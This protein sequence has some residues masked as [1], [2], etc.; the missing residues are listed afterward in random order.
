MELIDADA[1]NYGEQTALISVSDGRPVLLRTYY[2]PVAQEIRSDAPEPGADGWDWIEGVNYFTDGKSQ[3]SSEER[4]FDEVTPIDPDGLE[5]SLTTAVSETSYS[6]AWLDD[7]SA[8]EVRRDGSLIATTEESHFTDAELEPGK[9][10]AYSV[11]AVNG[12]SAGTEKILQANTLPPNSASLSRQAEGAIERLAV[13]PEASWFLYNTFITN[14]RVAWDLFKSIGGQ[15]AGVLGDSYGGDNRGF[16][17]PALNWDPW[18]T[19]GHRSG[20]RVK[21]DFGAQWIQQDRHVG[22]TYLY[23][24]SGNVKEQGTAS[25]DGIVFSEEAVSA[26]LYQTKISHTVG[27]PLCQY[28]AIRYTVYVNIWKSG[29]MQVNGS[30]QPIPAHEAYGLFM[31]S[32]GGQYWQTLYHGS[33]GDFFCISGAC[34]S[35][36]IGATHAP[37]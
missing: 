21:I 15:C 36:I 17:T 35:E 9:T 2:A 14:D 29:V 33:Q 10:Y 22:T 5:I 32:S 30:R 7:G 13:Q 11:L 26:S 16:M 23:D 12:E 20:V 31:N 1:P 8:Y 24:S 37:A 34:V 25:V 3:S 4:S 27:N 19:I 18:A 28:G 6:V